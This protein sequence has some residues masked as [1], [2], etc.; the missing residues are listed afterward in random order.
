LIEDPY[1]ADIHPLVDPRGS[2]GGTQ[3]RGRGRSGQPPYP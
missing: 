2:F 3:E 1:E